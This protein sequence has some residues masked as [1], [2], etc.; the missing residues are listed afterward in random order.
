M[1]PPVTGFYVAPKLANSSPFSHIESLTF[2]PISSSKA[3]L[4]V[5]TF[6]LKSV[7]TMVMSF[8]LNFLVVSS[9][10]L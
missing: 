7:T 3:V 5:P 1:V 6:A 10:T 4:S 9:S 2:D 8:V